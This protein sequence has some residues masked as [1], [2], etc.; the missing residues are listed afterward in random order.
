MESYIP[1]FLERTDVGY[2]RNM[3]C[4]MLAGSSIMEKAY[5][6]ESW[7]T[8]PTYHT[9]VAHCEYSILMGTVVFPLDRP[10]FCYMVPN[11][12]VETGSCAVLCCAG[13]C[14]G[15]DLYAEV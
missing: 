11:I 10:E 4:K 1:F 6:K 8:S 13:S 9:Q 3:A 12:D 2:I 5:I 15:T 7:H 14:C